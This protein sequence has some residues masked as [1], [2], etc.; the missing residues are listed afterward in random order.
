M[1]GHANKSLLQDQR[2]LKKNGEPYRL[3]ML[4]AE[5]SVSINPQTNGAITRAHAPIIFQFGVFVSASI[6][7]STRIV[8]QLTTLRF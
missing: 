2:A 4:I 8:G 6:S 3:N 5:W 1:G 7:S